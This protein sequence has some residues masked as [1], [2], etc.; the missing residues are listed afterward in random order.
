MGGRG[1]DLGGPGVAAPVDRLGWRGVGHALPPYVAVGDAVLSDLRDVGED[2]V[3]AQGRHG[4]GVGLLAGPGCDAE[5][6]VLGVDGAELAVLV[7]LDP[8]DVVADRP[9]LP[10]VEA[11][12][13]D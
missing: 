1:L 3:G 10:S 9:D 11:G 8:R 5:E 12:G 6:A 7:R 4:V 2:A 13:R